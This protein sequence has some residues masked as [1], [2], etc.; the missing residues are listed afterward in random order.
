MCTPDATEQHPSTKLQNTFTGRPGALHTYVVYTYTHIYIHTRRVEVGKPVDAPLFRCR[1]REKI[2]YGTGL[3]LYV[4]FSILPSLCRRVR[5]H[6][7]VL[8]F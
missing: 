5:Y 4:F 8:R 3:Y 2:R 1:P 7:V 6:V